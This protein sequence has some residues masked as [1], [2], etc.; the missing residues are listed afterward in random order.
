MK[1]TIVATCAP[2]R[3][4]ATSA[5]LDLILNTPC[6]QPSSALGERAATPIINGDATEAIT[7]LLGAPHGQS[8]E[9]LNRDQV[10]QAQYL[11]LFQSRLTSPCSWQTFMLS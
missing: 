7:H 10:Q 8:I 2:S 11:S 5:I 4:I 9:H 1:G 3:A 6:D